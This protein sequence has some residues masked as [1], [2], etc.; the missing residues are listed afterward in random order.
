MRNPGNGNAESCRSHFPALAGGSHAPH[1]HCCMPRTTFPE[2]MQAGARPLG[3]PPEQ[4]VSEGS[5]DPVWATLVP[6][7]NA[8]HMEIAQMAAHGEVMYVFPSE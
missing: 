5:S 8:A 6:K 4:E 1:R 2:P 7:G 3:Q